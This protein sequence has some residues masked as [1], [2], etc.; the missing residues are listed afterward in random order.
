MYTDDAGEDADLWDY[1]AQIAPRPTYDPDE[2]D[3]AEDPFN[4]YAFL[5]SD[6]DHE[7]F[8]RF[9]IGETNGIYGRPKSTTRLSNFRPIDIYLLWE[10][11]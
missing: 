10:I 2:Y 8:W 7:E 4:P 5:A 11:R 1:G 9:P 3:P 6:I